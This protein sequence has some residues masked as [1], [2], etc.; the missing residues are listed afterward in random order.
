MIVLE[1][2]QRYTMYCDASKEGLRYILMQSR[3]VVTYGSRQLNNHEQN[4]LTHDLELE[5]IV[6]ALKNWGHY[7]YGE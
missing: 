1:R 7:L 2:G 3:R 6:V 4:Y 5:A